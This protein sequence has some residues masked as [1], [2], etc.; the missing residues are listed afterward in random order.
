MLKERALYSVL[1][2]ADRQPQPFNFLTFN[3]ATP[4]MH[5]FYALI[6]IV[7]FAFPALA[8]QTTL[9]HCGTLIDGQQNQPLS[10]VT[11][12]VKGNRIVRVD[13]GYTARPP[14]TR[15]WT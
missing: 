6:L 10:Q 2:P 5:K 13:R 1:F 8:Q 4:F 15:W 3:L 14:A 12:V 9:L 7:L 11:I